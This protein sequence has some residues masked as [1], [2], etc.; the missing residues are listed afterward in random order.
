MKNTEH[1][2]PISG[3]R[4]KFVG[5]EV[6]FRQVCKAAAGSGRV[7]DLEFTKT[8]SHDDP[9]KLR[10]SVQ[11][12]I[13]KASA[14]GIYDA[15]LLGY[16]LCGNAVN[17]IHALNI[18]VVIPRA[19]DC[20]TVFL[21]SRKEFIRHFGELR[22][23][24]WSSPG[25]MER[26]DNGFH[27]PAPRGLLGGGRKYEDL[28]REHG[29]ENARYVM[30]MLAPAPPE[31]QTMFFIKDA[32]TDNGKY[33]AKAR[34]TA[35]LKKVKLKVLS[36]SA[37]LIN[38]LLSGRWNDEFLILRPG[39]RIEAVYDDFEILKASDGPGNA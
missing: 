6:F 2:N 22:S 32:G 17:G 34:E 16:G 37:R 13:E 8:A 39:Q 27:D 28:V 9:G 36:G 1:C 23:A 25:Y 31:R 38:R 26:G 24:E 11:D 20:C 19:H 4:F 18:P 12:K 14:L 10:R 15:V 33:I 7:I 35:A 21:G 30:D 29:E 3:S 5:C